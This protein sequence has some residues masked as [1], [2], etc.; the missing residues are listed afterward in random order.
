MEWFDDTIGQVADPL[1]ESVYNA[2][3]DVG[4]NSRGLE[5]ALRNTLNVPNEMVRET[6]DAVAGHESRRTHRQS[7]DSSYE[8]DDDMHE[9]SPRAM[10]STREPSNHVFD[11]PR[12]ALCTTLDA[13]NELVDDAFNVPRQFI[14]SKQYTNRWFDNVDVREPPRRNGE[15]SASPHRRARRHHASS[16]ERENEGE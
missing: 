12:R 2:R 5:R 3:L 8:S 4:K 10:R 14:G 9:H 15:R 6:L 1:F 13:T 7:H 11:I 16:H